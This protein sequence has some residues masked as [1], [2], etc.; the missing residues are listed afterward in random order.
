MSED[1]ILDEFKKGKPLKDIVK[2]KTMEIERKIIEEALMQNNFNITKTS[3]KLGLSRKGLQL[4]IKEL[5]I[6]L[7]FDIKNE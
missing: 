1:Q 7:S 5:G 6:Q 4:K 2:K 3:Q